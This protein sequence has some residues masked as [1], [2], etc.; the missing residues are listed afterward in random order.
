M[1]S[2]T[3]RP[4]LYHRGSFRL[5]GWIFLNAIDLAIP[6]LARQSVSPGIGVIRLCLL[7]NLTELSASFSS[8][9]SPRGVSA[10]RTPA[11]GYP[12]SCDYHQFVVLTCLVWLVPSLFLA[13][14]KLVPKRY[15]CQ[16]SCFFIQIS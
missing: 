5:A 6:S 3:F 13:K 16:L 15:S 7:S 11:K 2:S 12:S 4:R 10:Q 9:I 8:D 14:L 1:E